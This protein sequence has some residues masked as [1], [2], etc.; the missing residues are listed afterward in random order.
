MYSLHP[1]MPNRDRG[2]C[3][4]ARPSVGQ[5]RRA[6]IVVCMRSVRRHNTHTYN[7]VSP[8]TRR[9][10]DEPKRKNTCEN[11]ELLRGCLPAAMTQN[12]TTPSLF[13]DLRV[14]I[15]ATSL[16]MKDL[17]DEVLAL[18]EV[19]GPLV[20]RLES[21]E[22]LQF[23]TR[24]GCFQQGCLSGASEGLD[25]GTRDGDLRL[26]RLL[27]ETQ[28]NVVHLRRFSIKREQKDVSLVTVLTTENN[29]NS[30]L[31][32]KQCRTSTEQQKKM[33][34]VLRRREV[35]SKNG[36]HG[37][38]QMLHNFLHDTYPDRRLN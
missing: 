28:D 14:A 38:R 13:D 18:H 19:L 17:G 31:R 11:H 6:C 32:E 26:P 25:G 33:C 34:T 2:G 22:L 3:A 27:E 15:Y 23:F 12:G 20:T 5:K 30:S 35:G 10:C 29:T 7:A 8:P 21:F 4:T 9:I 24:C 37:R 36:V 1:S 16:P